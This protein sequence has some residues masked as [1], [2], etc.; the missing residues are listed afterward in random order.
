M[1]IIEDTRPRKRVFIGPPLSPEFK[2]VAYVIE[3]YRDEFGQYA[4]IRMSD[5]EIIY[6]FRG[7]MDDDWNGIGEIERNVN[8][9]DSLEDFIRYI[10][11][12]THCKRCDQIIP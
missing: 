7:S 3:D 8:L 11:T 2:D 4:K 1:K 5:I 12:R 9:H 6:K 10:K